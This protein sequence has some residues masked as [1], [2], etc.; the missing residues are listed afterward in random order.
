MKSTISA[1]FFCLFS[2]LA[3]FS[4]LQAD[5]PNLYL[6]SVPVSDQSVG[7]QSRAMPLALAQVLQKL[8]GLRNFEQFPE[9]E[10]AVQDARS[11]AITFYYRNKE[12]TLPDGAKGEELR[13]LA[14][15]SRPAVDALVQSLGLPIWKPERRPLTVWFVVDDG[16][17]RRILPIE[18]EYAWERMIDVSEARGMPVLRPQPDAEGNYPVDLQLLWGGYTEDLAATG[19][20]DALLIAARR[21]GPE[22]NV[23]MNMEYM[24]KMWSWRVRDID[25]QDSLEEGMHRAI[26]DIAAMNSIV[27]ADQGHWSFGITVTG[28]RT[29]NDYDR[30]LSYL[31]GVSLVDHV[32]VTSA[33]PAQVHF[34]LNLNALPDYFVR[35]LASDGVLAES[36][37][38]GE[39]LLLP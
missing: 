17:D 9:V 28:L 26:D 24:G 5:T 38:E 22:W 33:G 30:C 27:A 7:E 8:T 11:L 13:L 20:V 16:I 31:Q 32:R 37:A 34:D 36:T 39:Y 21:E 6:G 23:R 14:E 10:P 18:F 4:A 1:V 12:L 29:A 35:A 2:L 25:I 3:P 15:F 19:P